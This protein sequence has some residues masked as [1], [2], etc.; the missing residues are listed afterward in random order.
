MRVRP[1]DGIRITW[2]AKING[3]ELPSDTGVQDAL[4]DGAGN[5][6]IRFQSHDANLYAQPDLYFSLYP[7]YDNISP[8]HSNSFLSAISKVSDSVY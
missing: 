6:M 4:T 1:A 5:L 8:A 2:V 3:L 7:V